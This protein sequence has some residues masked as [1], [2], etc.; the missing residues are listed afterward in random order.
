MEITRVIF[1][2]LDACHFKVIVKVNV[3][4]LSALRP[5]FCNNILMFRNDLHG[6]FSAWMEQSFPSRGRRI[7][8]NKKKEK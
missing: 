7:I 1:L 6:R 4:V 2:T 3:K 8:N 5:G